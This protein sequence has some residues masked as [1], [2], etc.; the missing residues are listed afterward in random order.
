MKPLA[1]IASGG[2]LSRVLLALKR[3]LAQKDPVPVYVFDEVDAGVGGAMGE[4]IGIKIR[5]VSVLRQALCVTHLAQIAAQADHHLMVEK[6][7]DENR[8]ISRVRK[9]TPGERVEELAR[10]LGG[11]TITDAT[12]THAKD[13]LRYAR[14]V[15]A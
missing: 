8:T 14:G 11:L 4:A 15:A 12:R 10:M 2:E 6:V 3:V 9:L 5:G 13:M 7:V 1:K